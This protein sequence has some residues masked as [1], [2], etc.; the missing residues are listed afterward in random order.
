MSEKRLT[1]KPAGREDFELSSLGINERSMKRNGV[2]ETVRFRYKV[3]RK[4][5]ELATFIVEIKILINR[6][7]TYGDRS[8]EGAVVNLF[9][10][11][12]NEVELSDIETKHGEMRM[13]HV[14]GNK[15]GGLGGRVKCGK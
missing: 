13:K 8:C 2:A 5:R 11:V 15:L 4:A 10:D 3:K 14:G 6:M 12:M 9:F 1:Q 7:S